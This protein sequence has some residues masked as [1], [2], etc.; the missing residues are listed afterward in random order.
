MVI[1]VRI[2]FSGLYPFNKI[3]GYL[4]VVLMVVELY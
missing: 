1:I 3:I 4:E 2:E